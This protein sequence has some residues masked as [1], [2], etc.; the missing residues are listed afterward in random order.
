MAIARRVDGQ[1]VAAKPRTRRG[2]PQPR[3]AP[4]AASMV[5]GAADEGEAISLKNLA[6]CYA[7]GEG[8]RRNRALAKVWA[9]R[10]V[11]KKVPG[12]KALLRSL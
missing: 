6:L 1:P 5:G 4:P 10:A 2:V 12:A 3:E 7:N 11:A 8:V 9:R